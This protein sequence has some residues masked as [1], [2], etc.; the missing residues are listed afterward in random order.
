MTAFDWRADHLVEV[1]RVLHDGTLTIEWLPA[2]AAAHEAVAGLQNGI[3]VMRLRV[4]WRA[5]LDEWTRSA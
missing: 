2:Y 5:V 1:K 3:T 4:M